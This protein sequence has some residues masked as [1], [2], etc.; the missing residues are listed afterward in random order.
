M[1]PTQLEP[2]ATEA[3]AQ[4]RS[5]ARSAVMRTG[6]ALVIATLGAMLSPVRARA[7]EWLG[8]DKA[9]HLSVSGALAIGGYVL[10]VPLFDE[11]AP[12]IVLGASVALT[13]GIAK[14]LADLA[15]A[16]DPSWRDIFWDVV[17]TAT[18]VLLAWVV[19]L[20]AGGG[21]DREPV[22]GAPTA[23]GS[24]VAFGRW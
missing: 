17:G 22:T 11:R 21:D 12:R 3:S 20:V 18:G 2:A 23:L 14:E 6:A 19:D 16:G 7:D 13:L 15:G 9:L 24:T 1:A 4:R 8:A 10:A 5:G